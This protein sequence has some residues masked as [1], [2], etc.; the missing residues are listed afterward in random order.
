MLRCLCS[1]L[2]K[3]LPTTLPTILTRPLSL[4]P[5]SPDR[6]RRLVG[7]WLLGCCGLVATTVS[8]G[9]ITR[10][11]ESGLSM[12]DWKFAGRRAPR[13]AEEW[14]IE[15]DKYKASPQWIYQVTKI[16]SERFC[17]I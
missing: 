1:R 4:I 16:I 5:K 12:T 3:S 17:F 14:E 7:Y 10:L 13:T 2:P 9:G 11:T 8:V 15:F 6:R